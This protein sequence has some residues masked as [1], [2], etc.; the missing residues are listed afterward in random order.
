MPGLVGCVDA[1]AASS[2]LLLEAMIA[3]MMH[4]PYRVSYASTAYG[5]FACV[6][7]GHFDHTVVASTPDHKV[8]VLLDGWLFGMKTP[9]PPHQSMSVPQDAIHACLQA[10]LAYGIDVFKTLNGQF[11]LIVWDEHS[12][13][14]YLINDR[15]GLRPLQYTLHHDAL[16]FA[17]EAK[18]ILATKIIPERLNVRMMINQLSWGRI[19]IGQE[20]L[21]ENIF[22]FPPASILHWQDGSVT[23]NQYW[24][25]L[26]QPESAIDDDFID[27]TVATFQQSVAR[28]TQA[29]LRYGVSLSGGLDSR[30]VLAALSQQ[31]KKRVSAYSWGVSD[32]HDEVA[33]ARCIADHLE[34]PWHYIALKPT[35]YIAHA[36]QGTFVSEGL[37]LHVQSFG[38]TSYPLIQRHSDVLLTGLALDLTLGGSYLPPTS[39]SKHVSSEAAYTWV[40]NKGALFSPEECLQLVRL[41]E[42]AAALESLRSEAMR[43]WAAGPNAD[44]ADQCDRFFLRTRVWRYTFLRQVWQRLFLEDIAPTFDN[45]VI[46]CVLRIPSAWRAGHRFYQCFLQRLAPHMMDI[47]Y[48]NTMLPP[49]APLEFWLLGSQLEQ[50][51][52]QLYRDIWRTTQGQVFI[53]YRRFSTN[54]DEWLR[55][56]PAW[57]QMIDDLLLS[58]KSICCEQFLNKQRLEQL[59]EEHRLG[60]AANHRQI[61]QIMTL[62]L[63]LRA[64][65]E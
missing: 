29:P 5:A 32:L 1:A 16:Y 17:P 62:E 57:I 7:H 31:Q 9:T 59:L 28:Q 44:P 14:V 56:D 20:T 15:Y 11:N 52:E 26:Y 40:L 19:W 6:H 27:H 46:D 8:G 3:P 30:T 33:I 22:M 37:D 47:V 61:L 41:P 43:I 13:S 63:F 50:Q 64:F 38:L 54:Y 36:R 48:Q 49:A 51:R 35:D 12:C 53:P 21:F 18:A 55:R 58:K 45:A 42:T 4:Q 60:T 34:V 23:F 39:T 25:Y 65:F 10:Y 2:R 24:D